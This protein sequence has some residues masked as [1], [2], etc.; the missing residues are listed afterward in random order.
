MRLLRLLFLSTAVIGAVFAQ[1]VRTATLVGAVT[2]ASG[3]VVPN[4]AVTIT[5]TGTQVASRLITDSEGAYRAPF[6][7]IGSY[8]LRVE[9]AGFKRY[10]RTGITLNAGETPRLDV[11]LEVGAVTDEIKVTAAAP[12]LATETA[13]VGSLQDAKTIHDTPMIQSKPQH[14][15]YYMEGAEAMN[16]GTYHILGQPEQQ[17]GVSID[18]ASTKQSIRSA[19][20]ETN[21]LITPPVDSI[22]EAQVWTTGIPAEVGHAA[23]GSYALVTKSGTNDLHFSA[24]ERYINKD[25]LHSGYFQ[26][27]RQDS[28]FEYHNFDAT[29]GGPV[30]LPKI[31]DG[32]NK[33]FFFL[34]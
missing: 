9:A 20:G 33:T 17:L 12:L 28:P 16:N 11:V 22:A 27:V 19:L 24:E 31:Y 18:G 6:L 21:T 7:A 14:V 32:R 3:A 10:G 25:F 29:L 8:E 15:M 2:D 1:D 23:G 13:V 5:N 30:R 26:Q 34:A 4:A